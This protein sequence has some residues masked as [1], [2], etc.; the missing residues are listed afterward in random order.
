MTTTHI[1]AAIYAEDTPYTA[2]EL[3]N[4]YADYLTLCEESGEEAD[5]CQRFFADYIKETQ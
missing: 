3:A 5:D 1:E 2:D 4:A